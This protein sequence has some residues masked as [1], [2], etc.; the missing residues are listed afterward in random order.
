MTDEIRDEGYEDIRGFITDEWTHIE[1]RD[2]NNDQLT[3]VE[4][5]ED[6]R[7]SW[8]H[9]P[10]EQVLILVFEVTGSDDDIPVPS[11]ITGSALY[12]S[13]GSDNERSFSAFDSDKFL[14]ADAAELRVEH[15]VQVPQVT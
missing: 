2:E 11:T 4:I 3:R 15:R 1:L 6:D 8:E 10:E 13:G 14:E 9:E 12:P 7:T 5:D